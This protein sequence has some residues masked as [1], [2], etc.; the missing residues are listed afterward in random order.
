MFS[1]ITSDGR[2]RRILSPTNIALSV[3]AHVLLLGGVLMASNGE[4]RPVRI[5]EIPPEYFPPDVPPEPVPPPATPP[6]PVV[7]EE[8][9]QPVEGDYVSPVPP[10]EIPTE[11]PEYSPSDPVLTPEMTTGIGVRG[12][13]IGTPDPAD[14][15]PPTGVVAPSG[16]GDVYEL[17]AVTERPALRNPAEARRVLQRF[18]PD[19]LR[20]SGITGQTQL[21]FVV[22]AEGRVEPGTVTVLS[23]THEGFREASVKAAEKLR[24]RPAR[25]GGQGVRVLISMPITWTLEGT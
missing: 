19:L 17:P 13:V 5:I 15:R 4:P 8:P 14:R 22:D 2:R 18:Y 10:D 11:L 23:T 24:F 7:P 21:Q 16:S 3:G 6:E 12:D 9:G 1:K 25:I 20:E